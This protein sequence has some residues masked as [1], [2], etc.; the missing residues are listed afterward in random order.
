MS[1]EHPTYSIFISSF[2]SQDQ[3][4]RSIA[5]EKVSYLDKEFAYTVYVSQP[6]DCFLAHNA[7]TFTNSTT[8]TLFICIYNVIYD[9][10]TYSQKIIRRVYNEHL[11]R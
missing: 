4:S 10:T 9:L 3:T 2:R 5:V 7:S 6:Q 1:R 11:L 8:D